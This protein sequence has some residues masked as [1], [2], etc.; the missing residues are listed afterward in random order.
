[1]QALFWLS[2]F[3]SVVGIVVFLLSV[4]A[5]LTARYSH[6]VNQR[7][8]YELFGPTIFFR[9]SYLGIGVASLIVALNV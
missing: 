7:I 2:V 6:D 9:W 1:M 8:A 5:G 4:L 3:G